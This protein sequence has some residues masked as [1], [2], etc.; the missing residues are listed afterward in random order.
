MPRPGAAALPASAQ[1]ALEQATAA[2][3][4]EELVRGVEAMVRKLADPE[5]DVGLHLIDRLERTYQAGH[6]ANLLRLDAIGQQ[7]MAAISEDPTGDT[8]HG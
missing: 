5:L 1:T 8:S 4:G 2:R 7:A 6:R 3:R